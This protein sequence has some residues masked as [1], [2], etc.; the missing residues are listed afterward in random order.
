MRTRLALSALLSL[1]IGAGCS[2]TVGDACDE[3]AARTPYYEMGTGTPMYPGQAMISENCASCHGVETSSGAPE[4][5]NFPLELVTGAGADAVSGGRRLLWAQSNVHR[6]RDLVYGSV[7]NGSMPP[8]GFV[9]ASSRFADADGNPLPLVRS[10]AGQEMLRNWLACGS[11][12]VERTTPLAQPCSD[13]AAC[14]V[15]N[16]CDVTMGQCYGVGDVV[17]VGGGGS[18]DC[19]VPEETWTWIYTCLFSGPTCTNAGC[20]GSSAPASGLALPDVASAHAALVNQMPGAMS[21]SCGG[22]GP[23]V[24]PNDADG[25]LL[26]HKLEGVDASGTMVCGTRMPVGP[27][28]SQEEIDIVRAWIDAGAMND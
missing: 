26:I 13:N 18:V 12:V 14:E 10:D 9:P 21:A 24:I 25:S 7:V 17:A 15:T 1:A 19:D 4:G 28:L 16:F 23:Y 11:P 3:E 8:R 5:L 6:H 22:A 20:H 2:P 27:L